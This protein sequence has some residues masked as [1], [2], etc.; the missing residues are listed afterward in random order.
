MCLKN[1][2]AYF[3]SPAVSQTFE[4]SKR[5]SLN[6][7]KDSSNEATPA[8]TRESFSLILCLISGGNRTVLL[9]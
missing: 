8:V 5:Q 9:H 3:G 4:S 7:V 2:T 1:V 6:E